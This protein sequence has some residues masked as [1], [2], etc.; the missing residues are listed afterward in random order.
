MSVPGPSSSTAVEQRQFDNVEELLRNHAS[1]TL[2]QCGEY[3]LTI[4]HS[5]KEHF[6]LGVTSF[7]KSSTAKPYKLR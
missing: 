4:D 3:N 2:D 5:T 7:Y 6:W 1:K